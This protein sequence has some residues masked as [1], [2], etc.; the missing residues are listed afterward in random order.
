MQSAPFGV[1]AI[2]MNQSCW[3]VPT[4]AVCRSRFNTGCTAY[5]FHPFLPGRSSIRFDWP[6]RLHSRR[7]LSSWSGNST[8]SMKYG[9]FCILARTIPLIRCLRAHLNRSFWSG[10]HTEPH[11]VARVRVKSVFI[12]V[13][14]W[15]I[16]R[17][18]RQIS[19]S[20]PAF[21]LSLFSFWEGC[22]FGDPE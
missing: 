21:R 20:S 18:Y 16:L 7:S 2:R 17:L 19:F 1:V 15:L 13:H 11:D 10:P 6:R 3:R 9:W 4:G 22:R 12:R 8:T 5:H 14:P